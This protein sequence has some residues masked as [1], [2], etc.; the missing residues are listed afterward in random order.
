[1]SSSISNSYHDEQSSDLHR[2]K[3]RKL[4]ATTSN[5]THNHRKPNIDQFRWR[6]SAEQ[7]SYSSKLINALRHVRQRTA[8]PFPPTSGGRAVREAAD[9]ALAIAAKGRSHWSR[10]ILSNRRKLRLR[11]HKKSKIRSKFQPPPLPLTKPLT[12]LNPGQSDKTPPIEKR[13]KVLSRLVPGCRKLSFPNL[14]EETTDYIAALQMQVR[15]M[16]AL[17]ELLSGSSSS[18]GLMA[19]EPSSSIS[20]DSDR[21]NPVH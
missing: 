8:T 18:A 9:N 5:P 15:A 16:A 4:D 19:V 6:T 21:D 12:G 7:Q 1:M 20:N 3:R 11:N 13:V 14:L 2:K 10:A 17:A